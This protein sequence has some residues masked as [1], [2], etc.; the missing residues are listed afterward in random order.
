MKQLNQQDRRWRA[1]T[2]FYWDGAAYHKSRETL[3]LLQELKVPMMYSA[4]HSYE[5]SPCEKWF[6]LF[7]KVN[8]NP[9]KVKTGKR[10]VISFT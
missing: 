9:R 7:K 5:A 8:I 2:F 4:P 3:E 10:Y 6:A 1:N